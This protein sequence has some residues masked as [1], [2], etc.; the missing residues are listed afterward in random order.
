M[1]ANA[2]EI[3]DETLALLISAGAATAANA[4]RV[5]KEVVRDLRAARIPDA[6]I[7]GAVTIGRTVQDKPAAILKEAADVLTGSN[8]SEPPD[9][10]GCPMESMP[11]DATYL[12]TLL[13]AAGA[14]MAAHC[15]PCLNKVVPDLIEAGAHEADIRRAV[16][17]GQDVKDR[18]ARLVLQVVDE[19]GRAA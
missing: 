2:P 16:E 5:L 15:E 9:P 12:R 4:E 19:R 3:V 10:A 11:R 8:L 17:I 1:N 6:H 7:R 14:A 13:I 18:A